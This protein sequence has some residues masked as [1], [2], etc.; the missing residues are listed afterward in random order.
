MPK[1]SFKNNKI[2]K[3]AF[4]I[5][6]LSIFLVVCLIIANFLSLMLIKTEGQS[7]NVSSNSFEIHMLTLASSQVEKEAESLALD[8]QKIGAGGFIW[9]NDNYYHVVSSA[10]VNK[11]DATLVQNSVKANQGLD[12]QIISITFNSFAI[13][14]N[15]NSDEKKVLTKALNAC[16][17][18]Y[19]SIYDIAISLDTAVYN[20]ISARLAVNNAHNTLNN[21][22]DDF[23]TIFENNGAD[24]INNLKEAL[25]EM[26]KTS[27]ELCGGIK[28]NDNQN[29]SSILKYRY[30]QVLNIYYNFI[31]S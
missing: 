21:I 15:F 8:F 28:V 22:V 19:L 7:E 5:A 1:F 30:L 18:Y 20:E 10:Y 27:Q 3:R 17:D 26:L 13:S 6:F 9:K 14:G 16:F 25:N 31:N 2:S 12:S 29:Y 11:N 23:N 24:I 4:I